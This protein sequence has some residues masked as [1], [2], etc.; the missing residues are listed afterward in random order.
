MEEDDRMDDISVVTDDP[1]LD[2]GQVRAE[3]GGR[4]DMWLHRR[5]TENSERRFP[6]PDY[7][8]AGRRYW[9]RSTVRRWLQA[10]AGR[11]DTNRPPDPGRS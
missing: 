2:A 3:L 5:L 4:S 6:E 9:R 1:P 8:I 11:S 7:V 10:Q